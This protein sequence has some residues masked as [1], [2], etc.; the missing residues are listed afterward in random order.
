MSDMTTTA[1]AK[2]EVRITA[3]RKV[4]QEHSC[5]ALVCSLPMN[6]LMLSGYW[7]VVGTSM[8]IARSDGTIYLIVPEDEEELARK[9]G[10]DE[11][12]TF[13]P[14]SL[15]SL[16]TAAES[17]LKPLQDVVRSIGPVGYL[18]FEFQETS[19]PTS[20][21]AMHLYRGDVQRLTEESFGRYSQVPAQPM[22]Q[23]LRERKSPI[24]LEGIRQA[25]RIAG[26]AFEYGASQLEAGMTEVEAANL[27]RA[28]LSNSLAEFPEVE[29]ADGFVFC[30]SGP[31][32]AEAF[33]A[34]AR[35]RARRIKSGDL[36]L[37]HCN[38][39]ADGLWTD[40]TR[41]Y[42][43]GSLQGRE[44]EMYEA[45]FAARESAL[46]A[47][48][49]GAVGSAVDRA[50]RSTLDQRG[51]GPNFKHST[52]HGVG[53]QCISPDARPRLHPKSEDQ[54]APGMV[55]NVEPAIYIEHM[56]GIRH[57]DMVALT[58]DGYE[59]L[60][61]FHTTLESLILLDR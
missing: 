55:F 45:V 32:S 46:A 48:T 23:R 5:D 40:I 6:V 36:V 10:A 56:G 16:T 25:C 49:P 2:D 34:Y 47:L 59:L 7:P 38:S 53:F 50:A 28:M 26:R 29:R 44:E 8:A 14:S 1:P 52:G 27:F 51:F 37:V 15:D 41:T 22:L 61:P 17:I 13:H 60:T 19:A 4:L 18:A 43:V 30:M 20:Y 11:V 12:R 24:E 9:G 58:A 57:C 42:Q 31:N 21:A 33:G 3:I 54:L 39:Y 35:S